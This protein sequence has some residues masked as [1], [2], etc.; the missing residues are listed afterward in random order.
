MYAVHC[1]R[2]GTLLSARHAMPVYTPAA[3]QSPA[4]DMTFATNC[5]RASGII[6]KQLVQL[7]SVMHPPTSHLP[8]AAAAAAAQS[9]QP[10]TSSLMTG[11]DQPQSS[12]T[13]IAAISRYFIIIIIIII[14]IIVVIVA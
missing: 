1:T 5:L 3:A 9:Q 14:I 4:P 8:A 6:R 7:D 13:D 10:S 11:A 12:V 2:T